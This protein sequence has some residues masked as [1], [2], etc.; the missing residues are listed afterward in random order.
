[1]C[2]TGTASAV[3][4]GTAVSG[5]CGNCSFGMLMFTETIQWSEILASC[6]CTRKADSRC[7]AAAGVVTI[8]SSCVGWLLPPFGYRVGEAAALALPERPFTTTIPSPCSSDFSPWP[9]PFIAGRCGGRRRGRVESSCQLPMCALKSPAM[10][11]TCAVVT[12]SD[13]YAA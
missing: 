5:G 8:R 6:V 10:T 13:K 4:A 1:M 12:R 2:M 9:L 3:G 7:C 11:A